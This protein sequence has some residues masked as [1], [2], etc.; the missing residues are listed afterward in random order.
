MKFRQLLGFAFKH[1]SLE[2][3]HTMIQI[4]TTH[5]DKTYRKAYNIA[6]YI[7]LKKYNTNNLKLYEQQQQN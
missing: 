4:Y 6:K 2:D 7:L 1:W 5:K 3:C